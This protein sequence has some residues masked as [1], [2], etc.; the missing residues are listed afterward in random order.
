[1]NLELTE[2][3]LA[4]R[5]TVRRFLA[6]K[7]S[8]GSHVRPLLDD[9]TGTTDAVWRGL[10]ALG[11]T[12][13][14]V[15]E[16]Y[17]GAGMSMVEAGVVGEELGA[18][19]YPGPWRSSAVAA[20]RALAHMGATDATL[21]SGIADGT[22]IATVGPL[23]GSRPDVENTGAGPTVHGELAALPDAAAADVL[24]VLADDGGVT[25]AFAVDRSSPG[26]TVTPRRHVDPTSKLS[27]VELDHVPARQV[28][29]LS[30][31]ALGALTDDV[32][33]I[34]AADAIGAAQAV[35]SLAV[36]YAKVRRQFDAPIGSFQAVQH[37][38]VDMYETVEL[39]RSGVI[40]ALWAADSADATERHLAALR[41]KAFAGRLASVGDTA[42]QVFG[43]I[44]FTWEH[45]AHL[46]LKR[47]LG[48]SAMLGGS[49]RYLELVGMELSR[50]VVEG[51]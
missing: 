16:E 13:V 33:I 48:W 4:L 6:E 8:I 11:A 40:H 23:T 43:G 17:G 39:A 42:I 36:E 12:G 7:A 31:D 28:G 21:W 5:N 18:A 19:L 2:E 30:A 27:D 34:S 46:Y 10:T 32:L 20:T 9:P 25:G 38:C 29:V 41:A 45:D 49:D 47:L 1:M 51:I 3:Q 24:L 37:L 35:L 14:L 15:G 44:G 22:T 50:G 26:I